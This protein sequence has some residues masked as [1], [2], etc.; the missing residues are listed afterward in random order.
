M[1]RLAHAKVVSSRYD[2]EK[3]AFRLEYQP[4]EWRRAALAAAPF[5][6][7]TP[8]ASTAT[9]MGVAP[10]SV[11]EPF[12]PAKDR[13]THTDDGPI[14]N[15]E[16][17]LRCDTDTWATSLDIVIDPPPQTVS[18]LRRHRLSAGGGGAWITIEHDSV[19]LGEDAV[20][21]VVR[22]GTQTSAKDKNVVIVNGSKIK[23]DVQELPE[24]EVKNLSKQKRTKPSRIPLDQPPVLGAIRR[25]HPPADDETTPSTPTTDTSSVSL[26]ADP[27]RNFYDVTSR[28][29]SP[30]SRLWATV[31]DSSSSAI[32]SPPEPQLVEPPVAPTLRP[33]QLAL[34]A[35]DSVRLLHSQ[36]PD[37]GAWT[38]VV[39]KE[40]LLIEKRTVPTI[41]T[42]YP[43]HRASRVIQGSSAEDVIGV[44]ATDGCRKL[45][46]DKLNTSVTLEAYGNGCSLGYSTSKCTFPFRDRGF[47]TASLTARGLDSAPSTPTNATASIASSVFHVSTSCPREAAAAFDANKLNPYVLPLG[48]RVIEGWVME[49]R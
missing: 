41:S 47:L 13:T 21:V 10:V 15:V 5:P 2:L 22:K 35:L 6:P 8:N 42:A 9:T 28:F 25:R 48:H 31:P 39:D 17:E 32:A 16:C 23:V 36:A 43:V 26:M 7:F 33:M 45:W 44:V 46:D 30:L 20:L 1:T 38:L 14:P 3:G 4:A 37:P 49:V 29:T 19:L 34:N 24:A 27:L 18:C 12:L 40:G 11:D